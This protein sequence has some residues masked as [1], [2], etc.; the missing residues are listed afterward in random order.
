[1]RNSPVPPFVPCSIE[2]LSLSLFRVLACTTWWDPHNAVVPSGSFESA[3]KIVS[4]AK[5]DVPFDFVPHFPRFTDEENLERKS[6]L[7]QEE[8]RSGTRGKKEP[9]IGRYFRSSLHTDKDNNDQSS[10]IW[11]SIQTNLDKVISTAKFARLP[12][13]RITAHESY[14]HKCLPR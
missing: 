9:S 12:P 2:D 1:M 14:S 7:L 4:E 13:N 10:T 5:M 3:K 8:K 11:G 6:F